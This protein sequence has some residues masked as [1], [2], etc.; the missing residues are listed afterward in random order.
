MEEDHDEHRID[1]VNG[2]PALLEADGEDVSPAT[3]LL[4]NYAA[5]FDGTRD[6]HTRGCLPGKAGSASHDARR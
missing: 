5:D 3:G 2:V 1:E 6:R 4:D